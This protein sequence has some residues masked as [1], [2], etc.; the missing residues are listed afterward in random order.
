MQTDVMMINKIKYIHKN[1]VKR[2]HIDE[3][4]HC[5]HGSARD[6]EGMEGLLEIERVW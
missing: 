5:R 2:W 3:D 4:M 1:P 6:D